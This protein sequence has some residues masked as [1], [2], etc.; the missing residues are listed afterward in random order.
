[1]L[2]VVSFGSV[3]AESDGTVSFTFSAN[4]VNV[5]D[6]FSATIRVQ[7]I[8]A[9]MMSLAI[10]FNP[11]VVR[12]ATPNGEQ[13]PSGLKTAILL[14][15]SQGPAG[16]IPGTALSPAGWNGSIFD[17]AATP[18]AT[19]SGYPWLFNNDGEGLYNIFINRGLF[20]EDRLIVDEDLLTIYFVAIS[21][22][23]P[24]IRFATSADSLYDSQN[25]SGFAYWQER[26]D[27]YADE[28]ARR[29]TQI[30]PVN[31]TVTGTGT[32]TPPIRDDIVWQGLPPTVTVD[33]DDENVE[34]TPEGTLEF[35]LTMEMVEAYL[36]R[37]ANLTFLSYNVA[38]DA[39][40]DINRFVIT[41]PVEAAGRML[42]T[43]VFYTIFDTPIGL[44]GFHTQAVYASAFFAQSTLEY[45]TLTLERTDNGLDA[46][47]LIDGSPLNSMLVGFH[48]EDQAAVAFFGNDPIV[49]ARFN[50][51]NLIFGA[52][53]NGTYRLVS[54][55]NEFTDVADN[56]W[57]RPY[58]SSLVL[59]NII[60]GMGDGTFNPDGNITREQFC[61]II[62]ATLGIYNPNATSNFSDVEEGRWYSNYIASAVQ[63]GIVMGNTDG[64]FGVG[65]NIT[66]EEMATMVFRSNIDLI[67]MVHVDT[68]VDQADI[69]TWALP[70][71]QAMQ[72][73][74]IIS[75]H[76]DGRFAPRDTATRAQAARIMFGFL[77]AM[78][79]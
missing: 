4:S 48:T 60:N 6:V 1:M 18:G 28:P 5:G 74:A 7:D 58:I 47:V 65:N 50:G 71:V 29:P 14:H 62:V 13:V 27:I 43:F 79:Y 42:D 66:R 2:T 59:K 24:D 77:N 9:H 36:S 40:D 35:T 78:Y 54:A 20:I 34:V 11:Y 26:V 39:D 15:D 17:G 8:N 30:P 63:A 69:A 31:P 53:R 70:A 23:N 25:P 44:I 56:H 49:R 51:A 73:A 46:S 32:H 3:S 64:T 33:E 45:V 55:D 12:V 57:A 72:R 41:V 16:V 61:R 67:P 38:I 68:F 19:A 22:G 10:N 76:P 21:A 75:G 37:A 52:T